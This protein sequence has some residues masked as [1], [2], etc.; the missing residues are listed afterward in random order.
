MI[1]H[2]FK[3]FAI[4][5][6]LIL[7]LCS[8]AFAVDNENARYVMDA[9]VMNSGHIGVLFIKGGTSSSGI[10]SDGKLYFGMY[11][12]SLKQWQNEQPVG[13]T[14]PT[15]KEA[16]MAIDSS[17]VCH[18]AY[19]TEDDKIAYVRTE[20]LGWSDPEIIE[21]NNCNDM[22][23]TLSAPDIAVDGNGKVH[24]VYTDTQGANDGYYKRP[25]GMYATNE[26]DSFVKSVIKNCTGD[27]D[28]PDGWNH[29]LT[30]PLK[31]AVSDSDYC[32][33]YK[34]QWKSKEGYGNWDTSNWFILQFK[35]SALDNGPE[36]AT[37]YELISDGTNFY[38]LISQGGKYKVLN[39]TTEIVDTVKETSIYS[40]DMTLD[41][42]D[43]YYAAINGSDIIF[44][45][46]GTTVE[47]SAT[48]GVL[49]GH[50]KC[51]TVI[52]SDG[53]QYIIYTGS[54][55]DKSLVIS[56]IDGDEVDEFLVPN[57]VYYQVDV[58]PNNGDDVESTQVEEGD[59]FILPSAST[60][61]IPEGKI[62]AGWYID[63]TIYDEGDEYTVEADT[64]ITAQW[65]TIIT[66]ANCT[67]TKPVANETPDMVPVSADSEKYSVSLVA[68][69]LY[70]DPYDVELSSTDL[71]VGGKE[72]A[73][74]IRF[75]ENEGYR[76]VSGSSTLTING[77]TTTS[78]GTVAD[79]EVVYTAENAYYVTF[80]LAGG[81]GDIESQNVIEGEYAVRP[82]ENPTS[83]N[84]WGFTNWY[85]E[86]DE[87]T[88]YDNY[89]KFNSTPIT[90]PITLEALWSGT[91]RVETA[92]EDMGQL[93]IAKSGDELS[94][95]TTEWA[96]YA[97][98]KTYSDKVK[99]GAKANDGYSFVKWTKG[100]ADYSTDAETSLT[101][102]SGN[103]V[104]TAVFEEETYSISYDLDDGN[105]SSANPTEY[106]IST[107]SITLNIPTKEN[108][109][110]IGWTGTDLTEPTLTVTIPKGST[111][112]RT[113]TANYRLSRTLRFSAI[114]DGTTT[115]VQGATIQLYSG[116]SMVTEFVSTSEP[117]VVNG[118]GTGDF[119]LKTVTAPDGYLVP[120]D[121][122][123]TISETGALSGITT[124]GT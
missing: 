84:G 91:V 77:D 7:V 99:I 105:I 35:N 3:R 41:G 80:N 123:I 69:Y 109:E 31:I 14:A 104:L 44:Y 81:S 71:Y 55:T 83:E 45:Q 28:S 36:G 111:G 32:I 96:S 67:I 42:S 13:E 59:D 50:N 82:A 4:L 70:E 26:S 62:F 19:V 101:A 39:G 2:L 15:A 40:A 92:D 8:F 86:P 72:Y 120:E 89:F 11:D 58:D 94:Y 117:R 79:R 74:R 48:T 22:V 118:L 115:V 46:D 51:A 66:T 116:D 95:D 113:Y 106:T 47:G 54:D 16:S 100:G 76:F 21:S 73:Y 97:I 6:I 23:G 110:F 65:D 53:D 18:I 88:V 122:T 85:L 38:T 87:N 29:T 63:G 25:D 102:D 20:D 30:S 9:E 103:M 90:E 34:Y 64:T 124:S 112:N 37:I 49:S 56:T 10:I 60:L 17:G 93:A 43:I 57:I 108:W 121:K 114:Q 27:W 119:T 52:T 75:T 33:E 12:A 24:I 5:V 1:A 78:Y 98:T 68:L 61:T 107:N